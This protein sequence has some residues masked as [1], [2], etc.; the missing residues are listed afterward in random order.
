VSLPDEG[1]TCVPNENC[2]PGTGG[3]AYSQSVDGVV[4]SVGGLWIPF[5]EKK[6]SVR[7]IEGKFVL[8]D[9]DDDRLLG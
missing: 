8:W 3:A 7:V 4:V 2:T 1:V 6:Y 9:E 5:Y